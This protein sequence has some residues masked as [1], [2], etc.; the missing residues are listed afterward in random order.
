MRTESWE[1][2]DNSGGRIKI[3]S[4]GELLRI[5]CEQDCMESATDLLVAVEIIPED[6]AKL[7]TMLQKRIELKEKRNDF[8]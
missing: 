5:T 1:C 8:D 6:E 3:I 4:T 7:L 2:Q